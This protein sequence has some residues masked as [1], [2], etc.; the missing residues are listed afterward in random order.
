MPL[1]MFAVGVAVGR[2]AIPWIVRIERRDQQ[3]DDEQY[4]AEVID[5]DAGY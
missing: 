3:Q 1:F 2:G 4:V 5:D